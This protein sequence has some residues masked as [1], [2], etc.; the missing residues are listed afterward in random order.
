[1]AR[2][3]LKDCGIIFNEEDHT[4]YDP[5]QDKYLS[6]I[7]ALLDRQLFPDTYDGIP[8][9]IIQKAAEYGSAV[10]KACE[11]FD[12]DWVNNG[13]PELTDYIKLCTENSLIHEKSEYTVSDGQNYASNIDKVY[14]KGDNTFD[15]ADIKTYGVLDSQRLERG[16]WQLSIYA[17]M[18]EKVNPKAKV[19]KLYIIRLRCKTKADGS[20]DRIHELVPVSRIPSEICADL[21]DADLKGEQFTNPYSIP[22]NVK[23]QEATIRSLIQTKQIVEQ[24]LNA[25]KAEI[26]NQMEANDIKVWATDTMRITRKLPTTRLS[27][28]LSKFKTQHPELD[29]SDYQK[30][31]QVASSLTIT[32]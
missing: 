29:L 7:T 20:L 22:A 1:M 2:V 16:M 18:F 14:R 3:E 10:H 6:G 30:T 9:A 23:A 4:Y 12:T 24:Q 19:D 26:L 17:M 25:I 13:C 21:L 11:A 32:V 27:F 31:S 5:K 28:D 15:L 8:E